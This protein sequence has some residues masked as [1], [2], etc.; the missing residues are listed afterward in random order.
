MKKFLGRGYAP[1]PRGTFDR[2][3]N[4]APKALNRNV[5]EF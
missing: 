4:L 2:R 3:L 1:S 5:F